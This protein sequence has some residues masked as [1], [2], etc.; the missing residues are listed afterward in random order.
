MKELRRGVL[1]GLLSEILGMHSETPTKGLMTCCRLVERQ[2]RRSNVCEP[3]RAVRKN[4]WLCFGKP[5]AASMAGFWGISSFMERKGTLFPA[6]SYSGWVVRMARLASGR[7]ARH[8][9]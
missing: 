9:A 5:R 4:V 3:L 6:P 2:G 1:K 8:M 7:N